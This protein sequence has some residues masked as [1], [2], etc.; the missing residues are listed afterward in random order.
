MDQ[1]EFKSGEL[2]I[3]M[4]AINCSVRRPQY[5]AAT[6]AATEQ[7]VSATATTEESTPVY[8][9]ALPT[10]MN[11]SIAG[12]SGAATS[13]TNAAEDS[14]PVHTGELVTL[15]NYS[16]LETSGKQQTSI[17]FA[18]TSELATSL[19]YSHASASATTNESVPLQQSVFAVAMNS[20]V[21]G[22]SGEQQVPTSHKQF[23]SVESENLEET[24][25]AM[26]CSVAKA[27]A[28]TE[29]QKVA[30][31]LK[32]F[33][34]V[35]SSKT[36]VNREDQVAVM[37]AMNVGGSNGREKVPYNSDSE[38]A[39]PVQVQANEGPSTFVYIQ[40]RVTP[41]AMQLHTVLILPVQ[42]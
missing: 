20:S 3:G 6:P 23:A 9:G 36:E 33:V 28:D 15:T 31:S 32:Q 11:Y 41:F 19:E 42:K 26:N 37:K 8:S 27:S 35:S 16:I 7:L 12:A 22:G 14:I 30:A 21:A 17:S 5:M 40:N 34:S 25:A 2:V 4:K 24:V 1:G 13:F 18:A 10:P 39:P 29:Q 38:L